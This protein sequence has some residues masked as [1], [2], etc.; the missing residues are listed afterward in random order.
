M[1]DP[2]TPEID[3]PSVSEYRRLLCLADHDGGTGWPDLDPKWVKLTPNGTNPGIFSDQIQY[4]WLGRAKC[5]EFDLKKS[6]DLY[7]I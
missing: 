1:G 4:I 7:L 5:T 3:S 2:L 6:P